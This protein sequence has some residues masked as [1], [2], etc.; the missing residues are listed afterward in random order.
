MSVNAG[1]HIVAG[2]EAAVDVAGANAQLQHDRR[3]GRL[4]E[5]EALLHRLHDRRQVRARIEQPDLRFHR[6]GV[7][8]LLHDRG[9]FAIILADDDQRPAGH[10]AGG[11]IGKRIGGDIGADRRFEGRRPAQ[12]IIDR[13]GERGGR[14][15]LV[16]ARLEADAEVLQDVVGVGQHVDRCEI[17]APW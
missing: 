16:G 12:R 14:R 5:L 8:A 9:A 17:G 2:D 1:A 11:E 7:A 10:A 6:E 4:R 15:G 13:G 3:V